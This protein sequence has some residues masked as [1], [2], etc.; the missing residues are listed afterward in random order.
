ML[1]SMRVANGQHG[2]ADLDSAAVQ[3]STI[4]ASGSG[5]LM[6]RNFNAHV[7]I[8]SLA[9]FSHLRPPTMSFDHSSSSLLYGAVLWGWWL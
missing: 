6:T 2:L 8:F 7:V 9:V 3:R 5:E 4:D 1:E